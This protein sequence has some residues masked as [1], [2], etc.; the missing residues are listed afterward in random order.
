MR[1]HKMLPTILSVVLL[2]SVVAISNNVNNKPDTSEK[3]MTVSNNYTEEMKGI[4][5]TYMDLDMQSTDKSYDSFK[6]KFKKIA[7]T[8]KDKGFNSLIVQVRPF[9]DAL[10]KSSYFPYSHILTGEQGKNPNYDPLKFMCKYTHKL[11]MKI[12]A[13][14]NPYRI[15]TTSTPSLLHKSN[16]YMKNKNLGVK[17]D[18]GIYFNPALQEARE[19][20]ESGIKEIVENYDVDGIQFDDY[21]YPTQDESFDKKEY[22][23]YT[24][25]VGAGKALSLSQWRITNVNLLVAEVYNIIHSTKD[26][27][28]FGISPQGNIDNDY[29]MYADVK[30][31]CKKYGY[32]DYICPQL[33]YSI[34]S[35]ILSFPDALNQWTQLKYNKNVK[36]YIGIAGYKIGTNDDEGT[37][38]LSD[39]ILKNEVELLR[40]KG[41]SGVIFYSYSNLNSKVTAKEIN[42]LSKVLV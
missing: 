2:C 14:V 39:K 21:F 10:Y 3:I 6:S 35:P 32:I 22:T 23:A 9:C 17:T 12:H 8:S 11:G 33:Y 7:N 27:V 38:K 26:N 18:T 36:L 15:K 24:K 42:N 19:I 28:Q 5:V 20:I 37:W 40:K 16:P 30:N 31:W 25:T 4:W 34:K 1:F 29:N 13:W 41:A